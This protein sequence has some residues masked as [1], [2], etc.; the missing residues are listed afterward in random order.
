MYEGALS[1]PKNSASP[2]HHA[3]LITAA[4]SCQHR[5]VEVVPQ[6][7][8][9]AATFTVAMHAVIDRQAARRAGRA[10]ARH[11]LPGAGQVLRLSGG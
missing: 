4:F 10:Q 1:S 8:N 9:A 6:E 2:I 7:R 5:S 3:R 11:P